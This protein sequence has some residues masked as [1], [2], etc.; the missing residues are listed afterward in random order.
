[1][2]RAA[3][4][5]PPTRPERSADRAHPVHRRHPD[6]PGRPRSRRHLAA[7]RRP[8]PRRVAMPSRTSNSSWCPNCCSRP[9]RRCS[10]RTPTST[11]AP[12]DHPRPAHR[13]DLRARPGD[14]PVAR[15][16]APS[17]SATATAA[18]TTPPSRSRPRARSPPA[19]ARSSRGSPYEQPRPAAS[20][21]S[22][23]SP[24]SGRVGL[25]ICYDGSFPETARQLAWLGAEV[26]IQPTLTTTRD[27]EMELVCAR[28]NALDQPGLRRQRQRRRTAGVG[29][30]VVVDP[31]G[32]IMQHAGAGEEV[33]VDILDLDAVT[34]GPR[35][36]HVRL[37]PALGPARRPVRARALPDVRRSAFV[38]P[39][40]AE[41]GPLA[42]DRGRAVIGQP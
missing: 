15:A 33:L 28:A 8:G 22:S 30:S 39:A 9:R 2:P 10:S 14:R 12:H 37:E 4:P 13:P 25:A 42:R 32:M 19:T 5:S 38:P 18:S 26:I 29:A 23:T 11:S 35:V 27:R 20:S 1:M 21:S 34:R 16:R 31:E 3:N 40:W 41:A 36:R 7:V 24:A 6:R 17:T